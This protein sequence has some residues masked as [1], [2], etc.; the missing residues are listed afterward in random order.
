MTTPRDS[1]SGKPL[2]VKLGLAPGVRGAV[3][4]A[5]PGYFEALE[6]SGAQLATQLTPQ[7][8]F[9]Q[10]FVERRDTLAS[11]L[12]IALADL[13]YRGALWVSWPKR[14]SKVPTDVSE[15]VVREIAL[16]LGLVDVKVCAVDAVWSGL[17]LVRRRHGPH[18]L[19]RPGSEL[20]RRPTRRHR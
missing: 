2:T 18:R 14:A 12:P 16:P 3:L 7:L 9:I 4:H 6:L 8:A 19:A 11:M 1:G 13:A 5:P 20:A 17:K 15:D 10:L